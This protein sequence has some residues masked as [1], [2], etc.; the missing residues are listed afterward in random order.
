MTSVPETTRPQHRLRPAGDAGCCAYW[1]VLGLVVGPGLELGV[2]LVVLGVSVPVPP[3][4]ELL[5]DAPPDVP[6]EPLMLPEVPEVPD[7]LGVASPPGVRY[8]P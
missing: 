8:A 6:C 1:P 4:P 3:M 7:E 5:L 2:E